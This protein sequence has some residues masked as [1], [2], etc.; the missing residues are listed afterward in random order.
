MKP[1]LVIGA[2]TNPERYAYRAIQQLRQNEHPVVAFGLKPGVV[3]DVTIETEWDPEWKVDT[4][5]LYLNPQRQ[6]ALYESI[7]ALKP[8]RVIFNPGTENPEF[9]Q[10]LQSKGIFPEE[11]CTLVLLSVGE[12]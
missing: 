8:N 4:V 1:T 6:E 5:T 12:Y 11:A 3:A 10:L 7:I 2:T 9:E